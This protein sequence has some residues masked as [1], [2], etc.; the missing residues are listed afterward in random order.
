MTVGQWILVVAVVV[1]VGF[2]LWRAR[3]DGRFGSSRAVPAQEGVVVQDEV[4][5]VVADTPFADQLGERATFLQFSSAFCAPCRV[6][7]RTL[8]EVTDLL[9]DVAHVEVDAELHLDLVRRLDV[10]RTPTTIVLDAAGREVTRA[11]GAPTKAQVLTALALVH[12]S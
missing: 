2:G 7:R 4:V 12:D 6:T 10:L 9:P 3:M 11:A 1:A 8:E 5:S